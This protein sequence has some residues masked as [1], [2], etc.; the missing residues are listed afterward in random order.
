MIM[1]KTFSMF[2]FLRR[3]SKE[4]EGI[5]PI[6]LRITLDGSNTEISTKRSIQ[7]SKWDIRGQRHKGNTEDAKNLNYYLNT[8][9]ENIFKA[10]QNLLM[11]GEY[12]DVTLLKD[13]V[14]GK[15][16]DR[17]IV[18]IFHEHNEKLKSLIGGEYAPATY[19]RYLTTLKYLVEFISYQY[20]KKDIEIRKIDHSFVTGFEYFLRTKKNC[21]NNAAFKHVKNFGKIIRICI[22]NG[23]LEKSPFLNYKTRE[24]KV[25]PVFLLDNE[26]SILMSKKIDIERLA[27]VRDIFVFSCFT[28]LAYIDIANLSHHH[29]SIGIDGRKWIFICRKKTQESSNIPLLPPA[30]AIIEKYKNNMQCEIKGTLLPVLS[31]QRMNSYLKEIADICGIKKELTF[32]AARH[33]F[34]TTV[35][36][37]NGV[38]IESVSKMLGHSS[39]KMTQHYAK[40][41]D[42]KV[43][44]DLAG[45][46]IKYAL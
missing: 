35:T 30:N 7:N 12:V 25:V 45:L 31:N 2:F 22:A 39:I 15:T 9:K 17:T 19:Q 26:L 10:Y 33:T 44:Q 29:L 11:N 23:W 40:I 8:F 34:A 41:L 43:S 42:K 3:K 18:P 36:L 46:Q 21:E 6:Y 20:K 13:T 16:N 28:G 24:K 32:H 38:P 5:S 1:N 14:F 37:T 27:Q 4:P